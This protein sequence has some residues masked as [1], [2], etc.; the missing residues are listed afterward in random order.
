MADKASR[1]GAVDLGVILMVAAFAVIGF[2]LYWLNGQARA[3]L[4]LR[5]VEETEVE[6]PSTGAGDASATTITPADIQAG[7]GGLV[8]Q[9]VRIANIEVAGT[10]GEQGF[11]LELPSGPFLVSKSPSMIADQVTVAPG[12]TVTVTG[13]VLAMNDSVNTAWLQAGRITQG[14][15]LAASFVSHFIEAGAIERVGGGGGSF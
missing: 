13:T 9:V 14:D 10:L 11:W 5:I 6:E 4:A 3:E 12:S 7:V 2:F 8:G 15:Q 1:R